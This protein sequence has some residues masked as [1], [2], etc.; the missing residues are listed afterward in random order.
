M[1]VTEPVVVAGVGGLILGHILWLIGISMAR[2]ASPASIFVLMFS[3][4]FLLGAALAIHSAWQAYQAQR[5][6]R[7]AF[8]GGLA[9]S[10]VLFTIIV[11]G[12]TYL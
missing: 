6:T 11:L 3:A 9:V 2:A 10:P 5:W 1:P 4:L 8:L 7:A 12:V